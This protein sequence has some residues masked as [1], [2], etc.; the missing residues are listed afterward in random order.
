MKPLSRRDFLKLGILAAGSLAFTPYLPD[1][2]PYDE[3][4]LV[5]V[6]ID[7]ISVFKE[8]SDKSSITGQ[9][10][11]DDVI[12]VYETV[13]AETPAYNP[14]WYRVWGGVHEPGTSPK[15]KD[16]LQPAD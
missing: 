11:R 1:I 15:S 16:P 10:F 9:W 8:P 6:C 3:G 12:H 14:I 7:K 4:D 2:Q 5:R 13:T